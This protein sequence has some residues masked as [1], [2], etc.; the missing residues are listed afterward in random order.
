LAISP[1]SLKNKSAP[2]CASPVENFVDYLPPSPKKNL[3]SSLVSCGF[4]LLCSL[5]LYLSTQNSN[6]LLPGSRLPRQ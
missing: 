2:R 1:D 6:P 5:N 4:F 3:F